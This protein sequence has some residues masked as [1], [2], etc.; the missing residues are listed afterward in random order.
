MVQME[1]DDRLYLLNG[2]ECNGS[3]ISMKSVSLT[4]SIS[5]LRSFIHYRLSTQQDLKPVANPI[6]MDDGSPSYIDFSTDK[7][8]RFLNATAASK[9]HI[10]YHIHLFI[11]HILLFYI[12]LLIR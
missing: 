11:I 6:A 4:F 9:N 1:L 8:N 10:L 12:R 7:N 5:L 3:K 2:V